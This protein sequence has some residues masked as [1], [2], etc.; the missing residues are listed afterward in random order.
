[1][2]K[3]AARMNRMAPSGIRKVNEKALAMERAGEKV[4]HFEIGRPDFD[5][6]EYIKRAAERALEAPHVRV[7]G[8]MTIP[9]ADADHETTQRYF[10]EVR[11]LYVDINGKLFHNELVYL[12]MGMSGDYADAI[13][14]GATMVR[15][16][17]AIFGARDYGRL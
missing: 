14:A 8:L 4:L 10:Q 2:A 11:T 7:R 3:I 9:P 17:T 12:S 5:T 15:V 1:M 13:R 6:P 16:G